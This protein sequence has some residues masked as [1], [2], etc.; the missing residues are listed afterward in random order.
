MAKALH[1]MADADLLKLV[2]DSRS[3]LREL[4]FQFGV[5]RSLPNPAGLR[6]IRRT[7]AGA[8]T[9]L[10]ERKLGIAAQKAETPGKAPKAEKKK[11]E[12]KADKKPAKKAKG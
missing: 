1:E 9:V 6:T 8:L 11:A 3:Q 10:N 5:A 4:R 7:M 12:P 2:E